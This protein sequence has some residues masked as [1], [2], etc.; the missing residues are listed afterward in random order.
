MNLQYFLKCSF[1]MRR[2]RIV[3]H[4]AKQFRIKKNQQNYKR[5]VYEQTYEKV[6]K[7]HGVAWPCSMNIINLNSIHILIKTKN[8][9]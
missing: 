2:I 9:R 8:K 7:E 5:P 1:C 3:I 4:C 6:M